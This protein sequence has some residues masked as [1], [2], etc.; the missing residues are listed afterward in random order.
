[1]Q[2]YWPFLLIIFVDGNFERLTDVHELIDVILTNRKQN[3]ILSKTMETDFSDFHKM[4]STFMRNTYSRQEPIKIFYHN[5]SNFYN[6][7]FLEDFVELNYNPPKPQNDING[8]YNNLVTMLKTV[9]HKHAPPT[10]QNHQ[11]NQAPL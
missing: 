2:Q 5:F 3:F 6:T 4:V 1:M 8:E 7:K 9:L 11:G 10:K